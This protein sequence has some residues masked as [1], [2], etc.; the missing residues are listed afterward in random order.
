[1]EAIRETLYASIADVLDRSASLRLLLKRDPLR[2]YFA[3]VA[4]AILEVATTSVTPDGS[5]IGVLGRELKV[6]ECPKPL[7]PCMIEIGA[8]GQLAK[9][10]DEEDMEEAM[11]LAQEGKDIPPPRMERMRKMLEEG[12]GHD[13]GDESQGRRSVEGRAVAFTNRVNA[14]AL[15][16]T[17]LPQFKERQ[18]SVFKVLAGIGS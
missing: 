7:R 15:A 18:E 16:L 12:I 11:R 17:R 13:A 6:A 9:E 3:L 14:L 2:A 1:M 10:V 8:I 4:F 5:I